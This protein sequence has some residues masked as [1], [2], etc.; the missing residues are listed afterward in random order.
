M[1]DSE[2]YVMLIRLYVISNKKKNGAH[3]EAEASGSMISG[4]WQL[5]IYNNV[6]LARTL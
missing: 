5:C 2:E 1:S 4:A 6:N 3:Q